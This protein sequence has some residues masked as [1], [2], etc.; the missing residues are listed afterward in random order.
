MLSIMT[1]ILGILITIFLVIGIHEYGHFITARLC[2]VKVLRF[3]FGFGKTLFCWQDKRGTEYVI[4][5]IPLGGYVKMLDEAEEDVPT[6]QLQYAYSR[7]AIYKRLAIIIAG[8]LSNIIFAI[9]LY[10]LLFVI[11]FTTI[12]PI[13]GE[14]TPGSI[15][16]KA[17]LMPQQEIIKI[18]DRPTL[19][20]YSV[21][22]KMIM[23]AGDR[24]PMTI[25]T[26]SLPANKIE[27]H[28]LNLQNWHLDELRP[29][30]FVSIGITPYEP[31]IPPIIAQIQPNS[32]AA[33]SGL[34]INDKILKINQQPIHDWIDMQTLIG[35]SPGKTLII[36]IDRK[37][38]QLKLPVEIGTHSSLFEKHGYLGIA[39][40]NIITPGLLQKN[41]Y[42]L[43]A[44]V[45]QAFYETQQFIYL[46]FA[47]IGKMLTGKMSV[48]S[49]G[50]PITI[51]ES[52]GNA[53]NQGVI[54]FVSFLAFLSI[55]IGIINV[56]PIPGLDGGHVLFQLIEVI[57][58]RPLSEQ[59]QLLLYRFGLI[60]L[61]MLI[62]QSV[63]NDILRL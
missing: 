17:G 59:V 43:I 12:K 8:P 34:L 22:L 39:P 31:P 2:G 19:S 52:A 48:K 44:A 21:A 24:T 40:P 33:K 5:A 55:S 36:E 61:F 42:G 53:L 18:D 7:Q 23:R 54:S 16:A 60:I 46:N 15:A 57:I 62:V 56:L 20:W 9:I 50:G 49:L 29:D 4:S 6:D 1:S 28:T 30:P 14:V 25:Q 41:Q 51:F 45:P 35:N 63:V 32:P 10:W 26:S 58:R 27:S 11:G 37:G 38:K 3:S 13:I 47:V